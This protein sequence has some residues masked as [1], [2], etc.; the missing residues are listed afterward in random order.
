MPQLRQRPAPLLRILESAEASL[1]GASALGA[2]AL[3]Q[4][5]AGDVTAVDPTL[6][7][8]KGDAQMEPCE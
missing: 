3:R 1:A 5:R 8:C 7:L 6:A 4:A 2:R